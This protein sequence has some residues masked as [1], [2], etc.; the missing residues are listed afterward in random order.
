ME[1]SIRC[2]ATAA[3]QAEGEGGVAQAQTPECGLQVCKP[4]WYP[5]EEEEATEES[6]DA[7]PAAGGK[8]ARGKNKPRGAIRAEM[9]QKKRD[10]VRG[11][12]DA[13]LKGNLAL[14]EC[15]AH[16]EC[17]L[18]SRDEAEGQVLLYAMI[19]RHAAPPP[20]HTSFPLRILL[21]LSFRFRSFF[22][23][24]WRVINQGVGA[25]R[26]LD[27]EDVRPHARRR[28]ALPGLP[29]RWPLWLQALLIQG[30]WWCTALS[31]HMWPLTLERQQL[32]AHA[33]GRS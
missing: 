11:E 32:A 1:E 6:T 17:S 26:V 31:A 33:R 3:E 7:E 13:K 23:I 10:I 14:D 18:E 9:R 5:R 15:V 16:I 30:R 22:L 24:L 4:G 2:Y 28:A 25:A 20:N 27:G 8:G 29:R 19:E 12:L 21:S